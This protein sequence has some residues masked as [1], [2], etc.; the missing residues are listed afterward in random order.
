[1]VIVARIIAGFITTPIIA[2]VVGAAIWLVRAR[3]PANVLLDL[4]VSLISICPLF[5]HREKVLNR[6]R[7]LT[8]KFGPESIMVAEASDKRV[9]GFIAIDVGDGYPRF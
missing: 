1:M 6:V 4:R 8:E 2:L 5:R 7:P 9:D 3:S